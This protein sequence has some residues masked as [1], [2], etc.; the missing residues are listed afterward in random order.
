MK[1]AEKTIEAGNAGYRSKHNGVGVE[2]CGE[3]VISR[4]TCCVL[5]TPKRKQDTKETKS[6]RRDHGKQIQYIRWVN[7]KNS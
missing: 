4:H 2:N 3:E 5:K 6:L 7:Y 1:T